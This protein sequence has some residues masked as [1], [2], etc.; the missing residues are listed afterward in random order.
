MNLLT[1]N[2]IFILTI[3]LSTIATAESSH[4]AAAAASEL[5]KGESTAKCAEA[6]THK[7]K[8]TKDHSAE[9]NSLF[10]EKEQNINVSTRPS[11]VEITAPAFLSTIS[12]SAQ[13]KW[14]PALGANAY[15][16]QIATDPN[17]KWLVANDHF[18]KTTNYDF[19]A[20]ETGKKYFW[21]VA[22][23]N[24]DNDSMFTK[25]NFSSSVFTIK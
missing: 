19:T 11:V 14:K 5:C 12:G 7:P 4:N 20:K 25:S 21:R 15:H 16:V 9:M 1:Q 24:T 8:A 2:T 23:F 10:P 18:V 3:A 22:A 17:F 6:T 13:L